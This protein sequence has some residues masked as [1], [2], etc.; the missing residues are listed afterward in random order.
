MIIIKGTRLQHGVPEYL[1]HVANGVIL[2]SSLQNY[3]KSLE[4]VGLGNSRIFYHHQRLG[5]FQS[6]LLLLR[7]QFDEWTYLL[8]SAQ[9][10][11]QF[12]GCK[13]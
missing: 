7:R 4:R 11:A 10:H 9:I 12:V 3:K 1:M 6:F 5:L 2:G 13:G 8:V